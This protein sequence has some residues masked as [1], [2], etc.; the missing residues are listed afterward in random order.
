MPDQQP[1][2]KSNNKSKYHHANHSSNFPRSF[3]LLEF[4]VVRSWQELDRRLP[5]FVLE[6][7]RQKKSISEKGKG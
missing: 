7:S 2:H 3:F 1:N 6:D 4:F 5:F